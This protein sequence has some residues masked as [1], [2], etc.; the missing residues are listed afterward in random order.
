[1]EI[2][3]GYYPRSKFF[4]RSVNWHLGKLRNKERGKFL[5][6]TQ[7]NFLS[8]QT[9]ELEPSQLPGWTFLNTFSVT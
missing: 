2:V 3:D 5:Y 4:L 6:G 1:M 9:A 8:G 7:D